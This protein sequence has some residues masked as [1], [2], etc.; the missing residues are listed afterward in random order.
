MYF[1]SGGN[2]VDAR[3]GVPPAHDDAPVLVEGGGRVVDL[4]GEL[5]GEEPGVVQGQVEPALVEGPE[6]APTT[7]NVWPVT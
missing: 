2:V 1:L 3:I 6:N 7:T 5:G 4:P